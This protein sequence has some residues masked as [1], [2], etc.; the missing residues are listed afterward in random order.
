MAAFHLIIYGRFCVIT[1]V[2]ST[3]KAHTVDRVDVDALPSRTPGA[4]LTRVQM[5]D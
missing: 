3:K 2:L 5:R 4:R 1:E